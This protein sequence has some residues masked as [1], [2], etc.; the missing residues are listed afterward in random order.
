[1]LIL[2]IFLPRS[3]EA[4]PL[5]ISRNDASDNLLLLNPL[6]SV[7]AEELENQNT[8]IGCKELILPHRC[9]LRHTSFARGYIGRHK[10]TTPVSLTEL[11]AIQ[12]HCGQCRCQALTKKNTVWNKTDAVN[13]IFNFSFQ[14]LSIFHSKRPFSHAAGRCDGAILL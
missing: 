5:Q 4:W 1:M 14:G 6:E 12:L 3:H 2:Q 13:L 10:Q 8:S 9:N 11:L 7:E